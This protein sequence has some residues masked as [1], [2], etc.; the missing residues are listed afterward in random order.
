MIH[1]TSKIV[2]KKNFNEI[3]VETNGKQQTISI[4]T[5]ENGFGLS[6]NGGEMLFLAL[7]T[8]YCNDIYREANKKNITI[9]E[10]QID[11]S[12]EFQSDPGS[13]AKNVIFNV[14]VKGDATQERLI[15]LMKFTDTVSEI[16]NTLRSGIYVKLNNILVNSCRVM[17]VFRI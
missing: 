16:Q 17:V 15:E 12:G 7:A 11:V 3:T 13:T 1:I 2:N 10:V 6:V 4:K 9:Q 8:C 14:T 5:K